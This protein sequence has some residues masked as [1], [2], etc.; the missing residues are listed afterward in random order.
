[1]LLVVDSSV[2]AKSFFPEELQSLW[3]LKAIA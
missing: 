2:A 1:M 3:F